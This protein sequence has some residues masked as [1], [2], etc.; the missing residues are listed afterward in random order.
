MK[1]LTAYTYEID[2]AHL[3]LEDILQQLNLKKNLKKNA[4]GLITCY[5]EFIDSGV[6]E[7]LCSVLPFDVVGC[8]TISSAVNHEGGM[9]M[10]AISVLTSDNTFFISGC[11][12]SLVDEQ[13]ETLKKAYNNVASKHG[14]PSMILCYIPLINSVSGDRI[15]DVFNKV[16]GSI[17]HFGTIA[18]DHHLDYHSAQTI[19]NGKTFRN[20]LA[21]VC[22]YGDVNPTF[23]IMSVSD[24]KII[25][26]KAIITASKRN[27]LQT[28]NNLPALQY[29]NSLGLL[30]DGV[31]DGVNVIPFMIDYNDGTKPVARAIFAITEEGYAVCAGDMPIHATISVGSLDHDEIVNTTEEIIKKVIT[32]KQDGMLLFSCI[33]RNLCLGADVNAEI[34]LIEEIVKD[35]TPFHFAYSGG[36]ICP[37]YNENGNI[38]N[39]LHNDTLI[40][41]LFNE[42]V[43]EG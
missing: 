19:Y 6:V 39:R 12:D 14:T 22:F 3:A 40:I 23:H 27:I 37:V 36:E 34:D 15:L 31:M 16:N 32:S 20:E 35:K 18:V 24:K 26:Q 8:T 28:V 33:A 41:C 25:K 2:D 42:E 21:F 1:I 17:P 30:K 5:S 11:S 13:E 10:L 43:R 9:L 38:V 4:I 7:K 29:L